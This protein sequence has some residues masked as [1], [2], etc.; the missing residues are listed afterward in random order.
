MVEERVWPFLDA[1]VARIRR[2]HIS[3]A[4]SVHGNSMRAIRRYFEGMSIE[5]A[6]THEN[7]LGSDYALYIVR[8]SDLGRRAGSS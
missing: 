2:E 8:R 4:L 6:T 7:P 5:E 3:V 1:L